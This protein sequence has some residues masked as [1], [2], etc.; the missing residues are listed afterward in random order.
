MAEAPLRTNTVW[1]AIERLYL[2]A[3]RAA[4]RKRSFDGVRIYVFL[5]DEQ[6]RSFEMLIQALKLIRK[7]DAR[8]YQRFKAG[9]RSILVL[10]AGGAFAAANI[11]RR[12]CKLDSQYVNDGATTVGELAATLVHEATHAH[13][14]ARGLEYDGDKRVRIE[15]ICRSA[16]VA[17]LRKLPE[18]EADVA[19]KVFRGR[20]LGAEVFSERGNLERRISALEQQDA[21]RWLI[22]WARRRGERRLSERHGT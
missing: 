13:V 12:L 9:F 21:P 7:Y 6:D 19:R 22:E 10:E 20:N 4:S 11:R 2:G 8:R 3:V 5:P 1:E 16:E 18:W 17:F 15:G 14:K